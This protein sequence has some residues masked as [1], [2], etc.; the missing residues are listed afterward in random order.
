MQLRRSVFNERQ[1][2]ILCA[3]KV[4]YGTQWRGKGMGAHGALGTFSFQQGKTLTCG[5][6]GA[7]MTEDEKLAELAYSHGMQVR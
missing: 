4:W 1:S 7:V 6:G 2:S 5:E 3:E